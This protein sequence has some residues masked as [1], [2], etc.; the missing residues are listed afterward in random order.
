MMTMDEITKQAR[1]SR[2]TAARMLQKA[3][4]RKVCVPFAHGKKHYWHVTPA[5][6]QEIKEAYY[7][8][9]KYHPE[10]II[11]EQAAALSRLEACFASGGRSNAAKR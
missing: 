1:I 3:N 5:R 9:R 2:V 4:V 11:M 10:K 7:L 6:L 8:A